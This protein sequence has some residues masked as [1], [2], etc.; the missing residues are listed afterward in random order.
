MGKYRTLPGD[1]DIIARKMD[2][3]RDLEQRIA[4]LEADKNALLDGIKGCVPALRRPFVFD[5]TVDSVADTLEELA[6]RA[7]GHSESGN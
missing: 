3:V 2:K 4:E 5:E 7:E 1:A 6:N